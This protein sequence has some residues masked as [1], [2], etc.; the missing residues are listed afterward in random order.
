MRVTVV[1]DGAVLSLVAV[2]DQ[3]VFSGAWTV[4]LS[5]YL[6]D[7]ISLGFAASTGEF[8]E[9][10][11]VRSWNFSTYG[12]EI[13]GDG[14]KGRLV[15]FLAVFIPLAVA[16]LIMAL[17]LWRRLTRRTRLAYRNLEKMIDAHGPVRFKLR[18]LRNATA[19]IHLA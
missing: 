19:N 7:D 8:A 11:Q 10:N 17:L 4:D 15:L 18:E 14:D 6:L 1:Y 16:V 12:D 9:L 5:R 3:M 2:M 13:A